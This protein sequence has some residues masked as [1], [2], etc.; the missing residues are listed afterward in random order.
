[1]GH[2]KPHPAIFEAAQRTL[3]VAP[4]ESIYIGDIYAVDYL[5]AK[6]AGMD[7]ILMDLA[8]TYRGRELERVES[9]LEL[10]TRLR[11][12]SVV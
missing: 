10:E 6:A 7:A 1:M 4:A 3:G 9:M 12:K 5:G 8:G 11:E 2:E